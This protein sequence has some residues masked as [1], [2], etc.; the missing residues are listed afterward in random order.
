MPEDDGTMKP[1]KV[2]TVN[3]GKNDEAFSSLT[4]DMAPQLEPDDG[5][6]PF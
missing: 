3:D 2:N 1:S 6:P 4:D 5:V